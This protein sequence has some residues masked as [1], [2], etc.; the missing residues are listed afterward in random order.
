M[1]DDN[2]SYDLR[3]LAHGQVKALEYSRYD[4]NG[5]HFWTVK[6]EASHPLAATCNSGVV[7]SDEDASRVAADYYGVI[8]KIIEYMFRGIKELNVVFFQCDWFD[9]IHDTG[10]DDFAMVEVKH[11]SCYTCINLLLAHQAQ[12]V[13]YLSYHHISMKNWWVVYKINPEIHTH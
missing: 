6:L 3:Q 9:P 7:T 2:I 4:I 13:Y 1:E 12:Q 8:Q 5:Y 10:V 11:E